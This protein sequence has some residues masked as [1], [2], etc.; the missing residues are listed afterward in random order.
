MR[1]IAHSRIEEDGEGEGPTLNEKEKQQREKKKL[2]RT[3]KRIFPSR[4]GVTIVNQTR[5]CTLRGI[6]VIDSTSQAILFSRFQKN[7]T[8][9]TI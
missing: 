2:W 3:Q 8:K 9:T 4:R 5:M 6:W 1:R 7:K